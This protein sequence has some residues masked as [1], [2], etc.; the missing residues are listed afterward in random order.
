M[1]AVDAMADGG[2]LTLRTRNLDAGWIQLEVEDTGS[3]M[4]REV[5]QKALN[6]FFTTKPQGKGTGL[7]L[8]MVYSTVKAHRGH[9]E[10]RSAPG[11]GT[12]VTLRFPVGEPE[13]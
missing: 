2:R 9:M 11:Q 4:T 5:N 13:A 6:P 12:C 10:I 7:G 8:S 3:G 1:N